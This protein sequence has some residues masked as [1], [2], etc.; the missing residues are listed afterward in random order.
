MTET[1]TILDWL[2]AQLPQAKMTTL[3]N[4]ISGHRVLRNGAPVRSLKQPIADADKLELL[5]ANAVSAKPQMLNEKL[6]LIHSDSDVLIIDKPT[7]L[8]TSTDRTEPR[9]TVVAI[10]N[11]YVKRQNYKA[12]ALVVHRLDRDASGLLMFARSDDA[13]WKLKPQF[14]NH[15]IDRI[16]RV[17]VNGIVKEREG[18]LENELKEDLRGIVRVVSE[19][20]DGRNAALTYKVLRTGSARSLLE[21]RLET[22]RKHQIRVQL[23]HIGHPVCGDQV[24][25]TSDAKLSREPPFR[26]ALHATTLAFDHPRNGSRVT[27]NSP[28]PTSFEHAV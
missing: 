5:D 1:T 3:R 10:L 4:L 2:H 25:G 16:Y 11:D 6:K 22:G 27:F 23:Q 21:C 26:L 9:P 13:L 7:G 20:D 8:L 24:Y 19:R 17:V 14:V 18:R 15:T 28:A 12:K